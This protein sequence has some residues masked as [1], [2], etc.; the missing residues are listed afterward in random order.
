MVKNQGGQ[1]LDL[2][3]KAKT[4]STRFSFEF[5]CLTA[6]TRVQLLKIANAIVI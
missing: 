3:D 1:F 6:T 4:I 2:K 5:L